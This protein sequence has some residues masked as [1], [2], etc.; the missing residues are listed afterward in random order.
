[1]LKSE[2]TNEDKAYFEKKMTHCHSVIASF[3]ETCETLTLNM[4]SACSIRNWMCMG[5]KFIDHWVHKFT[6]SCNQVTMNAKMNKICDQYLNTSDSTGVG[7]MLKDLKR[8]KHALNGQIGPIPTPDNLDLKRFNKLLNKK[9]VSKLQTDFE[10]VKGT[11]KQLRENLNGLIKAI[12][13][14]ANYN[15]TFIVLSSFLYHSS[16]LRDVSF[17]NKCITQYFRHLDARRYLSGKRTLMPLKKLERK[18]LHYPFQLIVPK[19]QRLIMKLNLAINASLFV[20]FLGSLAIDRLVVDFMYMFVTKT[21]TLEYQG[22][23]DD[24]VETSV[25]GGG[26]LVDASNSNEFSYFKRIKKN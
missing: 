9:T 12:S 19:S 15:F 16:Y 22:S 21:E 10:Y 8:L 25:V 13:L 14:I 18:E 23:N 24:D 1:M 3:K 17:D 11:I 2:S 6:P 7:E 26:L 20:F 4:W 5:A